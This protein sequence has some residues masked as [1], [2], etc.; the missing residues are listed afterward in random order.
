[1]PIIRVRYARHGIRLFNEGERIVPGQK[2]YDQYKET[3]IM[4]ASQGQLIVMLYE[5][6]IRFIDSA[7][8]ALDDQKLDACNNHL[9]RAQD[10]I[11]ELALSVNFDAGDLASR[12]YSLYMFFNKF[13]LEANI[14]KDK[15][16]MENVKEMLKSLLESWREIAVKGSS[17]KSSSGGVNVAG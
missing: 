1:M 10:I 13:L 17:G 4:T 12:L 16:S 8:Q 6:A 5:G 3:Q 9:I 11:T 15:K 2:A 7:M 14:K